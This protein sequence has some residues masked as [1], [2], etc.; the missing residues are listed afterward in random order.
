MSIRPLNDAWFAMFEEFNGLV[1]FSRINNK[2]LNVFVRFANWEVRWDIEKRIMSHG[3]C[4]VSDKMDKQSGAIIL[5]V[6]KPKK[7]LAEREEFHVLE[8]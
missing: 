1:F 5:K 6:L 2:E 8:K 3:G 7:I 4:V